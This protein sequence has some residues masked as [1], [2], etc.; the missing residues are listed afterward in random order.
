L[1][2][3]GNALDRRLHLLGRN[4][5]RAFE[6]P[7][8]SVSVSRS[9]TRQPPAGTVT[10]QPSLKSKR[11]PCGPD[12]VATEAGGGKAGFGGWARE[13]NGADDVAGTSGAP[14]AGGGGGTGWEVWVS[15]IA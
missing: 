13:L 10:R 8:L 1:P 2:K 15:R 4:E 12:C 9:R 11:M 7:R 5:P 14:V 6:L 3:A